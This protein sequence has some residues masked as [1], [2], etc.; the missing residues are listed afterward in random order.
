MFT[1]A[2]YQQM[3]RFGISKSKVMAQIE[4]FHKSSCFIRLA[5]PCIPGDGVQ[6]INDSDE[7]KYLQLHEKAAQKGRFQKFVPASGAAT[8]MFQS[9]LQIYHMPHYLGPDELCLKVEQGVS[10]ACDFVRFLEEFHKFPFKTDF[11][12]V[13]ARDGCSIRELF[14]HSQYWKFL[15][16]LLTS[17]GLN[18]GFLPKALIKF[19]RYASECRTALEEHL[20]DASGYLGNSNES[21]K[22]HFTVSPEHE[23]NFKDLCTRVKNRYE[24]L[25]RTRFDLCF[26]F[27]KPSTNT[28]AVDL[29]NQ[30]FRDKHGLLHFRPGGHGAL[31]ENLNDTLGDLV[32]IKNIDNVAPDRLKGEIIHWKRILGGLLIDVQQQVHD[33]VIQLKEGR[34]ITPQAAQ[35]VRNRLLMQL[36]DGFDELEDGRRRELLVQKLNRPIRVCGV[37]PN[38]GE[39][40]GAPFW[41]QEKDGTLSLQIIEKAQVDLNSEEQARIWNSSTHFNPVDIVCGLRDYRGEPFD[42]RHYV[43]EDAVFI[44]RK[45]KDGQDIKVLELPGLWNG[46]MSSWI[47]VIVEVPPITFN[48]VKSVFDLLRPEHQP[49]DQF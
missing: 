17:R 5:K 43:D 37:V 44:S 3:K 38:A 40:G 30:P 25:C 19:H 18:Y 2:D 39:P 29:E 9:L 49:D 22:I 46:S 35:F 14:Q 33:F 28:I 27:Q 32:Y 48:P 23:A 10:V 13:L 6:R 21:C 34:N 7:F 15:E 36:P 42:L 31:I 26:S 4:A 41:V 11:E 16:Y 1:K 12:Q 24:E 20:V 8:R 45:S 47:T